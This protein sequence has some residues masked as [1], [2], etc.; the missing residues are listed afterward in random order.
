VACQ[1]R[2]PQPNLL[3][4]R[5]VDLRRDNDRDKDLTHLRVMPRGNNPRALRRR[6]A[7]E[8]LA[9]AARWLSEGLF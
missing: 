4:D 7:E 6:C 1:F 8:D 3:P 9:D 2:G 5:Y